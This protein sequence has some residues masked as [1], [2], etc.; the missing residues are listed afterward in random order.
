MTKITNIVLTYIWGEQ[1][2]TTK[3]LG[4]SINICLKIKISK[5]NLLRQKLFKFTAADFA[6]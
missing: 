1:L 3:I 4:N 2:L 6:S 5:Y